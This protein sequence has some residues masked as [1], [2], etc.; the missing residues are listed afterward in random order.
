MSF[1]VSFGAEITTYQYR[2][3]LEAGV[4]TPIIAQPCPV[5]VS[6]IET[7]KPNLIQHLAPT[8]SPVMD[9]AEW[10]H[11]NHPG[12]KL[13]FI[14]PCTAKKREFEDPN[15]KGKVHYNVTI[16]RI[17][18]YLEKNNINLNDFPESKFDGPKEAE[19][20]LLYSQPG[21]LFETFKRYNVK[22][23]KYQV[24]KVEGREIYDEYFEEL[25]KDINAG[26]CDVILVDVLNCLHGCNHG[27]GTIYDEYTTD[28]ILKRQDERLEKHVEEHYSEKEGVNELENILE[29]MTTI[30]FSR[31]YTD[32]SQN[33]K[34]LLIPDQEQIDILNESMGKIE[35][36]DIKNCH[37]CGYISCENMAT[38]IF[39]GLYRPEQC[40]HY[41][42]KFYIDTN[43]QDK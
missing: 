16:K 25:E 13:A 43:L 15:T 39:N 33:F 41:L 37:A 28:E 20:G 18:E 31:N 29:N 9:I 12:N 5:V 2:K 34:K 4:K 23:K 1:D 14:S 40:Q 6:Y 3:A 27:T 17:K 36:A 24:R 21:G 7:Y 26:K 11:H 38:A 42:E 22:L 30:D 19:R 8:G 35:K 32:K 10:A